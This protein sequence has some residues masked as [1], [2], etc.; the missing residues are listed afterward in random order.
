ML[1]GRKVI[2]MKLNIHWVLI[3]KKRNVVKCNFIQL[4]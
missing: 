4:K 1:I 2:L 3:P